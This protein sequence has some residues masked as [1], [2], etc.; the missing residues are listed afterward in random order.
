MPKARVLIVRTAGTNCDQET[1]YA[2][3]LAGAAV[4]LV[5]TKKLLAAPALLKDHHVFV[6]PGGFTYGDDIA[7]GR[8]LANELRTLMQEELIGHVRRGGLVLGVCNGFQVLVKTGLLPGFSIVGTA[9][10]DIAG[11]AEHARK[12]AGKGRDAGLPGQPLS[13][14]ATL[15]FNDSNRY[16]DRWVYLKVCAGKSEFINREDAEIVYLPVAHGEGKF[17]PL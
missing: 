12:P 13:Q 14:V 11:G 15:M 9:P 8:V 10:D 17:V 1:R 4:S 5:H 3:E 16:E 6:I 7:A 2:F